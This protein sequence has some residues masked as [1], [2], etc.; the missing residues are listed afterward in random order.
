MLKP[1][2]FSDVQLGIGKISDFIQDKSGE[3][4]NFEKDIKQKRRRKTWFLDTTRHSLNE[5]NKFL[6]RVR[7]EDGTGKYDTTLKCR[8][9]DRY[10]SASYDL[11]V[12][13]RICNSNS[14]KIFQRHSSASFPFQRHLRIVKCQI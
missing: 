12:L 6:L 7:K 11:G 13:R 5:R 10:L 8:H 4:V 1:N 3:D 14:R 9:P 2:E